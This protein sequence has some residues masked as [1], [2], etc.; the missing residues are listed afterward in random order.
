MKVFIRIILRVIGAGVGLI[1]GLW[2]VMASN[3]VPAYLPQVMDGALDFWIRISLLGVGLGIWIS[4]V[5]W[6][7]WLIVCY[8]YDL[9]RPDP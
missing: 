7:L 1:L 4:T 9:V 2:L 5:V 8:F 3:M 6:L